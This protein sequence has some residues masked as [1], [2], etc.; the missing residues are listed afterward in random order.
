MR[1]LVAPDKFKNSLGA[2]EVAEN[3]ALGLR[4]VL[5]GAEIIARPVSDGGEGFASVIC[6]AAN[7]ERHECEVH[8]SLGKTVRARYCT[9]ENGTTAVLEMSEAS[10]L[11]RVPLGQRDPVVASSFGTGEMILDA[12]QGGAKEIVIGLGGSAT[13]DGGF[14]MARALG[15]RFLDGN[16]TELRG[17]VTDLLQLARI[18]KPATNFPTMIAAVDVRN[19]LLGKNGATRIF[20][21]Q[22]GATAEQIEA[23]ENSLGRLADVIAREF[24]VDHRDV[25]GAGAAGGLGFGLMSFCGARLYSGFEVVAERVDLEEAMRKADVIVTG[26]GRLD[27]QTS[28][29]KAP[30]GVAELAR[31]LGKPAY[32]IVGQANIDAKIREMF[33]GVYELRRPGLSEEECVAHAP[34]LLRERARELANEL[35]PD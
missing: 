22:K 20:G 21:P 27:A 35:P 8:N 33:R 5:P 4:E 18:E 7:G 11:W 13:N 1:I 31:R 15:F 6:A 12:I 26:E 28:E 19:H 25:P 24:G 14:G 10:G 32:A 2:A 9:I 3:I 23:L 29:G 34:E 30:A 17:R 16:S